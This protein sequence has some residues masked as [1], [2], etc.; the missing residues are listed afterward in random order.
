MT[1]NLSVVGRSSYYVLLN[2]DSSVVSD[3]GTRVMIVPS[4]IQVD[5]TVSGKNGLDTGSETPDAWYYVWMIMDID[6]EEVAGLLSLSSTSPVMP[7][8][9]TK[10]RLVSAVRN[11][12]GDFR[13]YTQVEG[14][15]FYH[16]EI[17]VNSAVATTNWTSL[18]LTTEV[19]P[20]S[21]TAIMVSSQRREPPDPVLA[22]ADYV[23]VAPDSTLSGAG[24]GGVPVSGVCAQRESD[25]DAAQF[26]VNLDASHGMS[27]YNE[28]S[29]YCTTTM[30]SVGFVMNL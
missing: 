9:F 19:P 8:G 30:Y 7:A 17:L 15:L 2:E 24:S 16:D 26:Y 21:S 27:Y 20:I 29:G 18:I 1:E 3:D 4:D 11:Q 22:V 10:K 12:G 6:T 28:I 14:E 5:I 25:E 23:Y 13:T